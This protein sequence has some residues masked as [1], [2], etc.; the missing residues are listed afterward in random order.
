G[1]VFIVNNG[2]AAPTQFTM[3]SVTGAGN[4]FTVGGSGNTTIPGVISTTTGSVTMNGSGKL[5]LDGANT[6]SGITT[7]T[8][9]TLNINSATAPG[10]GAVIITGG[11]VNNTSGSPITLTNNNPVTIG[12]D[13]TFAGSQALNMGVGNITATASRTITVNGS[14]LTLGGSVQA[15]A[16]AI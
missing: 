13:F 10:T 4:S 14:T 7:L 15:G 3:A 5:R 6:F 2:A 8:S 9:S 12:G 1:A 11:T 16:G